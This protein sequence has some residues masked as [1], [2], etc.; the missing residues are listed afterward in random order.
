MMIEGSSAACAVFI[1]VQGRV[2]YEVG[3]AIGARG[4]GMV[5]MVL[6]EAVGAV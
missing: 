6:Y 5:E 2:S 4:G 3:S 1:C